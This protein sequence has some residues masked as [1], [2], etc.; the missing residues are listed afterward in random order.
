MPFRSWAVVVVVMAT[1]MSIDPSHATFSLLNYSTAFDQFSWPQP[2]DPKLFFWISNLFIFLYLKEKSSYTCFFLSRT[3]LGGNSGNSSTTVPAFKDTLS[4]SGWKWR[5]QIKCFGRGCYFTAKRLESDAHHE[6]I[7]L[8]LYFQN[9]CCT[10]CN[11]PC[12]VVEIFF[13]ECSERDGSICNETKIG[14][15]T[16]A[17]RIAANFSSQGHDDATEINFRHWP[18]WRK[19]RLGGLFFVRSQFCT[20]SHRET[21][22]HLRQNQ[23]KEAQG[24]WHHQNESQRHR[25]RKF[26]PGSGWPES[27]IERSGKQ[28]T[29]HYWSTHLTAAT[30]GDV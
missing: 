2:C 18:G 22:K 27:P 7:V 17:G 19:R 14:A 4:S 20:R 29:N 3:V 21:W 26:R 30:A 5:F 15:E 13:F 9:I 6:G 25:G 10:K 1:F 23:D 12:P 8:L 11:W 28:K 24:F 16:S